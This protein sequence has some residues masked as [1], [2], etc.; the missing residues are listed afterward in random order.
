MSDAFKGNLDCSEHGI[1]LL[2]GAPPVFPNPL[3]PNF[4]V[5][6][7]HMID[8]KARVPVPSTFGQLHLDERLADLQP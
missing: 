3:A 2:F 6:G 1:P 8:A 5:T 7:K 4:E